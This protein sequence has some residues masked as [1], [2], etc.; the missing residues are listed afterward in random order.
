MGNLRRE[1]KKILINSVDA[2]TLELYDSNTKIL[3]QEHGIILDGDILDTIMKGCTTACTYQVDLINV[4]PYCTCSQ[5][6]QEF[7]IH[8]TNKPK[9]DGFTNQ[10]MPKTDY[11]SHVVESLQDCA[12]G[13][14][15]TSDIYAIQKG[16][17]SNAMK[18]ANE[19]GIYKGRFY[20]G[21]VSMD[22]VN[23][24]TATIIIDGTTYTS[25][26]QASASAAA[27]A[28]VALINAGTD[29]YA[30][31]DGT[32][33][34]K[35]WMMSLN[36]TGNFSTITW[37]AGWTGGAGRID[38]TSDPANIDE[39]YLAVRAISCDDKFVTSFDSGFGTK[40]TPAAGAYEI[41]SN[42]E[43]YRQ[44]SVKS[45]QEGQRPN[46]PI[47][48]QDYCKYKFKFKHT[49]AY[50]L[51][52][53]NHLNQYYDEVEIYVLK[54]AAETTN[55]NGKFNS[56]VDENGNNVVSPSWTT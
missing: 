6:D 55:W 33:A 23:A 47:E 38:T 25:G 20:V 22:I 11:Y 3:I 21:C 42:D 35:V 4:K 18:H 54:S 34:E 53:A 7:G 49:E 24:T 15:A 41:L 27:A 12:N 19:T 26:V 14:I 36:S 1:P 8:I 52:G 17:A 28:L 29:A 32:T 16:I 10:Y 40:T 13:Y 31:V 48:G 45:W 43:V 9:H 44:F 50:D 39:Y 30:W 2:E 56:W 46:I 51:V 5:C 37:T